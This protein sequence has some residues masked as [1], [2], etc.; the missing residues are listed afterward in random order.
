MAID[1]KRLIAEHFDAL[2]RQRGIDKVTV[3]ALIEDCGISRQTFYYHF[4]DLMDVVEWSANQ[5]AE[6]MVERS[7]KS[8]STQAALAELIR[9][10]AANRVL[11]KKLIDSQ[12]RPQV[13]RILFKAMHSYLEELLRR[14][15]NGL[16]GE[17][18][19]AELALEFLSFGLAGILFNHCGDPEL[20]ADELAARLLRILSERM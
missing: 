5:A 3:T 10:T 19:D 1:M 9:S 16:T 15:P 11:I 2:V 8:G 13:E 14:R 12:R 7:L 20:D 6:R 4:Q 18:R 17:Y